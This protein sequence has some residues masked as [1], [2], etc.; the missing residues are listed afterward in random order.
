MKKVKNLLFFLSLLAGLTFVISSCVDEPVVSDLDVTVT[1]NKTI[2]MNGDTLKITIEAVTTNDKITNITAVKTGGTALNVPAITDNKNYTGVAEYIV[3]DADGDLEFTVTVSSQENATP[4]VKTLKVKVV[5]AIEVTL[6]ATASP[7]P[8]FINGT[9]LQTY[10]ATQAFA[11]QDQ[12]DLVYT[13]SDTEGAIIGAPADNAFV[14]ANW[15]T[16]HTTKIARISEESLSAV[17]GVTG[18]SVRN[19]VVGDKLGYITDS[20]TQG[21]II[22]TAI[23]V[24]NN[25]NTTFKFKV[26]K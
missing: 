12:V 2:L 10:T 19:L 20:G 3:N 26:I 4:V 13:W 22:V 1:A 17:S 7:L 14:L 5:S 25:G 24:N 6:G 21:I 11:N 9:T 18:T 8:S 16:K 23:V 15:T